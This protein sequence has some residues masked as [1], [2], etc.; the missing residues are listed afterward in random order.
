MWSYQGRPIVH[1]HW[2]NIQNLLELN[3]LISRASRR[4]SEKNQNDT[5]KPYYFEEADPQTA[6]IFLKSEWT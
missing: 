6:L 2:H 3:I 4:E 1:I 5:V